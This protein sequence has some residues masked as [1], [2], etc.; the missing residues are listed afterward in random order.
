MTPL[1]KSALEEDESSTHVLCDCEAIFY[2][3][4]FHLDQFLMESSDYYDAPVNKAVE[5]K[6]G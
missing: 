5:L 6:K 1:V 3:R 2:L 4:F